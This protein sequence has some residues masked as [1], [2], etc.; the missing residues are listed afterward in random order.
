MA[1]DVSV[2]ERGDVNAD[3]AARVAA[4]VGIPQRSSDGRSQRFAY[5]ADGDGLGER[6]WATRGRTSR[7][8]AARRWAAIAIPSA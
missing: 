6:R 1:R 4:A 7:Q 2:D 8:L 5:F 3:S